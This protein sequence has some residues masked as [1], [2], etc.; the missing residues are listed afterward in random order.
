M[1]K[2]FHITESDLQRLEAALPRIHDHCGMLLNSPD[3]QILFGEAKE[4]LSNV[5]W[6]Y[7]PH[8]DVSVVSA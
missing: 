4:I 3:L 5:R 2:L 6:D 1:S 7:G 8:T